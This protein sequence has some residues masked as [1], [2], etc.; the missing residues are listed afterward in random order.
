MY[1]YVYRITDVRNDRHYYGSRQ[2]YRDPYD[3]IG[4]KYFSSSIIVQREIRNRPSDFRYKVVFNCSNRESAY[5]LE[6][7]IQNKLNVVEHD[8]FYNKI[9]CGELNTKHKSVL[10]H[11]KETKEKLS[12]V[13]KAQMNNMTKEERSKKFGNR[14]IMNPMVYNGGKHSNESRAK[15]SK[16][17]KA[18]AADHP[19]HTALMCKKAQSEES[20]KKRYET[21]KTPFTV[22]F[23]TGDSVVLDFYS[24]LGPHIGMSGPLGHKLIKNPHLWKKYGIVNICKNEKEYHAS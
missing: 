2:S 10:R 24:Q 7:K 9:L 12:K 17:Q 18:W 1:Y 21:K 19:E 11:T 4:C 15:M 13:I 16:F 23:D 14:G 20:C 5:R 6:R 3:D 22:E 8:K